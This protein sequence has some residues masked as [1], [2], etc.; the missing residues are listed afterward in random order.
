[1][2]KNGHDLSGLGW[3]TRMNW[4]IVVIYIKNCIYYYLNDLINLNYLDF[5]KTVLDKKLLKIFLFI[6]LDTKFQIVQNV[7]ILFYEMYRYIKGFERSK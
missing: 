1:M 5:V 4:W 3:I 2:V 6:I 7:C